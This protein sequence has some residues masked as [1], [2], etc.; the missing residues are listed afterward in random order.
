M[1]EIQLNWSAIPAVSFNHLFEYKGKEAYYDPSFGSGL[2]AF[3]IVSK[4]PKN[5]IYYIGKSENIASRIMDHLK[6][7][8]RNPGSG[9]KIPL[10]FENFQENPY[11][12]LSKNELSGETE[13]FSFEKR[14]QVCL[15]LIKNSYF[16]IAPIFTDQV[17]LTDVES[18]LQFGLCENWPEIK[19]KGWIGESRMSLPDGEWE[20]E[21]NFL[22]ERVEIIIGSTLPRKIRLKDHILS[23]P[24]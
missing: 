23:L 21:N 16:G 11:R 13:Q 8:Y 24:Q 22:D 12:V 7:E 3:V 2:Y 20:I 19:G 18:I 14:E 10:S 6:K 15:N 4:N 17:K 5:A 1:Q 9:F